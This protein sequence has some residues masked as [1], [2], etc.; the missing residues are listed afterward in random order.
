MRIQINNFLPIVD[1][2]KQVDKTLFVTS[3]ARSGSTFFTNLLNHN[4]DYRILFEPLSK[5]H[6]KRAKEVDLP[7]YLSKDDTTTEYKR[8]FT[9]IIKGNLSNN[10]IDRENKAGVYSKRLIKVV[11]ANMLLPWIVSNFPNL[12]VILLLRNPISVIESWN[13]LNFGDGHKLRESILL[14]EEV[15]KSIPD[16]LLKSYVEENDPF[17]LSIYYWCIYNSFAVHQRESLS[18]ICVKY[19]DVVGRNSLVFDKVYEFTGVNLCL[20]EEE[21]YSKTSSSSR[22]QK[23]GLQ[24]ILQKSKDKLGRQRLIQAQHIIEHFEMNHLYN[25]I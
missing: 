8:F 20:L 24:E 10:W 18:F 5:V 16:K 13:R 25:L 7:I 17:L 23:G 9:D 6:V 4:N 15:A 11:R 19:E 22:E 2:G 1:L 14:Y 3:Q 12:K 21:F